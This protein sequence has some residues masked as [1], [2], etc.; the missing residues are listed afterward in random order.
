MHIGMYGSEGRHGERGL[1]LNKT[2]QVGPKEKVHKWSKWGR[3]NWERRQG[4]EHTGEAAI[5]HM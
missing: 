5:S 1:Y 4:P 2:Q 3:M